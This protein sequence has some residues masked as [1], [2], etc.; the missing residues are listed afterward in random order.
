MKRIAKPKKGLRVK[1]QTGGG[2]VSTRNP[3]GRLSTRQKKTYLPSPLSLKTTREPKL[4][5]S[6]PCTTRSAVSD[7]DMYIC[8]VN[9]TKFTTL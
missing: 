3:A 1:G 8:A 6:S 9:P 2:H 5:N 7:R 4:L